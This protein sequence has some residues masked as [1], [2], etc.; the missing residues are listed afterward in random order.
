MVQSIAEKLIQM[1]SAH[2]EIYQKNLQVFLDR[3][4]QKILEWEK[5]AESVR[6]KEIVA[7]HNSWPYLGHFL[8]IRIEQFLE[9]KPGIPP[10]PKHIGFLENYIQ[11]RGIKAII[12]ETFYPK[13]ASEQLAKRAEVQVVLL[14]QNVGELSQAVD[15]ISMMDYNVQ[16][17]ISALK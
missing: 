8:G 12:Q 14:C 6:A 16:Q 10:T 2:A 1:D 13:S 15:Y 17:L 5:M 4:D 3:L 11:E 9:P 7:Y